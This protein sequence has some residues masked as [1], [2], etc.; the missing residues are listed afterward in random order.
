VSYACWKYSGER[1]LDPVEVRVNGLS[2]S[3]LRMFKQVF[4]IENNLFKLM[5]NTTACI[6]KSQ[7]TYNILGLSNR[8][9]FAIL[10][11]PVA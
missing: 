5:K 9:S 11:P 8:R 2:L 4:F 7:K 10:P 6:A 3:R 1:K